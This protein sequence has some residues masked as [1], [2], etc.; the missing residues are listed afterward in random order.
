MEVKEGDDPFA[1]PWEMQRLEKKKRVLN[2]QMNHLNNLV[3]Y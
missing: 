3:C 2:N 1:D